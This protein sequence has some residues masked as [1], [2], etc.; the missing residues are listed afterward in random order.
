M[1]IVIYNGDMFLHGFEAVVNP[2]NIF[3]ISGRG[4][5]AAFKQRF[6]ENFEAYQDECRAKRMKMGS[7]FVYETGKKP[8]RYVINFPS[9]YKWINQ[10]YVEYIETGLNSLR[11]AIEKYEITGYRN[12]CAWLWVGGF[13]F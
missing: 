7:V 4:L 3:G 8:T 12:P 6:P 9:K 2:V 1:H 13:G 11:E 5:A 10:S